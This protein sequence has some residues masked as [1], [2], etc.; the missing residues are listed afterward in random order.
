MLL[1]YLT[2]VKS[3][4]FH[5]AHIWAC[6]PLKGD[7]YILYC[8]PEEQRIP[9]SDRLR[10]WYLT[11]LCQAQAR[12]IVVE[13]SNLYTKYWHHDASASSLPYFEGDYW[14][15]VAEEFI[16]EINAVVKV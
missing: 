9:K 8:H 16:K 10:Q 13:I 2:H 7:D 12:G 11:M 4:G 14:V 3:R 15:G 5:T 1:A 6:P